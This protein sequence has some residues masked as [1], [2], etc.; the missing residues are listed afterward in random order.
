MRSQ[1]G[2]DITRGYVTA[3][4]RLETR[5][6][7]RRSLLRRLEQADT[8]TEAEALRAQLDF[9][10]REISRLRSPA[11]QPAPASELLHGQPDARAGGRRRRH[12]PRQ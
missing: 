6:A 9:N 4:D 12:G 11:T 5:R 3:A 10:A 7:E 8:D 2:Q 1:S